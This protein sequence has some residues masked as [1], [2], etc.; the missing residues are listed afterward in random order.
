MEMEPTGTPCQVTWGTITWSSQLASLC[1]ES[2]IWWKI[3]NDV[4]SV[5]CHNVDIIIL[6]WLVPG[7]PGGQAPSCV[8]C[9]DEQGLAWLASVFTRRPGPPG[10]GQLW[11]WEFNTRLFS[12]VHSFLS[13]THNVLI[14]ISPRPSHSA[15]RVHR[16]DCREICTMTICTKFSTK[17]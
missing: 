7:W 5:N 1:C 3:L 9:R 15:C 2:E 11:L 6:Q 12:S 14:I 16:A 17:L 4:I 8:G 13:L 10:P